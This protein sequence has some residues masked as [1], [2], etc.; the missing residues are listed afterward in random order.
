[1][2][3]VMNDAMVS[4]NHCKNQ[5]SYRG[6]PFSSSFAPNILWRRSGGDFGIQASRRI[7]PG[8]L[9]DVHRH[10]SSP[11]NAS[12]RYYIRVKR[13]LWL[14]STVAAHLR[15]KLTQPTLAA[16]MRPL[17]DSAHRRPVARMRSAVY[18]LLR[19]HHFRRETTE[20]V[21]TREM[22]K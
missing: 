20:L 6:T 9:H 13:R 8:R 16:G 21:A 14:F 19:R 22:G 12:P 1:M 10:R 7:P 2:L 18:R 15:V 17:R 11:E 4:N 3:D 5:T